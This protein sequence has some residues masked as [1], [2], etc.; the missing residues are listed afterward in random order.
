VASQ[1]IITVILVDDHQI[2]RE[3]LAKLIKENKNLKLIAQCADGVQALQL[4]KQLKPD[5]IIMDISMPNLNGMAATHLIVSEVKKTRVIA[6]SMH[7][8]IHYVKN[9]VEAGALGYL[10]KNSAFRELRVAVR[11]VFEGNYYFS[12]QVLTAVTKSFLAL[13]NDREELK[14]KFRFTGNKLEI[15]QRLS[16][17]MIPGKVVCKLGLEPDE[18]QNTVQEIIQNWKKTV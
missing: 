18:V 13:L 15:L 11:H 8:E 4:T 10:Q 12:H 7:S 5:I 3:G 6:L 14:K 9:M 2:M 1:R 16:E 17:G